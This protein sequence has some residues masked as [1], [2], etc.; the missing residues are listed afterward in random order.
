MG[1]D[2]VPVLAASRERSRLGRKLADHAF[3]F[4]KF[5]FW[6][7]PSGLICKSGRENAPKPAK[8]KG[9]RGPIPGLDG[10]ETSFCRRI[11]LLGLMEDN[12]R[13]IGH[14]LR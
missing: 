1:D 4:E 6:H 10:A 14:V 9:L 8:S 11:M 3:E 13:Q 7:S 12:R 5:F 2:L